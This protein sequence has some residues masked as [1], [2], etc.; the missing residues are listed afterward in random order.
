M[1]RAAVT[2]EPGFDMFVF[3]LMEKGLRTETCVFLHLNEVLPFEAE[4][5]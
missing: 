3:G 2:C 4:A 5:S 1:A